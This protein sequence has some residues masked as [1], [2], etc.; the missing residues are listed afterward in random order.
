MPHNLPS[1][2]INRAKYTINK[3]DYPT[4][5]FEKPTALCLKFPLTELPVHSEIRACL[6]KRKRYSS[7]N[8]VFHF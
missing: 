4:K 5:T 6:F 8:T 1:L 3:A 2:F 7:K